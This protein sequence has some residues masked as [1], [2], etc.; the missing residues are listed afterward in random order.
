MIKSIVIHGIEMN[1]IAA[2]ERYYTEH[3][4]PEI[5]R[6]YGPWLTRFE[7]FLSVTP[8]PEAME[9]GI[10]NWRVTTGWWRE[11]PETG[12]KGTFA[13]TLMPYNHKVAYC[14]TPAQPTEDFMGGELQAHE[15]EVLRWYYFMKYPEGVSKEEGEDWFLNVHAP[16][17][18]KQPGLYRFFS[19][20]AIKD[21]IPLPGT[22]PP[23]KKKTTAIGG[24][25]WDR[26]CELWYETFDDW[27]DS[28]INNPPK[29]TKPV[30]AS[31][32]KY[33]FL[34]PDNDFVS[35]FLLER[36]NIDFLREQIGC[37]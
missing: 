36:P 8:P 11:L 29:Y 25:V 9:Y 6:R 34:E 22:W 37:H 19:T 12:Y 15:K 21:K 7:S 24:G 3:H 1:H 32:D 16:E 2:M 18:M 23:G 17:V 20:K 35:L 5:A 28:V 13:F 30:W 27:K 33:P 26:V 31:H 4:G 10:W 14:F